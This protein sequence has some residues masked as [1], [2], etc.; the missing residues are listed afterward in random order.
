MDLDPF[1]SVAIGRTTVRVSRLGYGGASIGGLFQA[2]AEDDAVAAVG[3]SVGT[4]GFNASVNNGR[5]FISLKPLSVRGISSQTFINRVR[6][7]LTAVGGMR[8]FM[9]TAQDIRA[10]GR[11]TPSTYQ[12]TLWD[13]NLDELQAYVPRV[14]ARVQQVPEL[15]DV[16]N[17]REQG[18][19]QANVVIDRLAAALPPA[20]VS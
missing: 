8:V 20:V 13:P 15:A 11:Q 6:P 10:G 9:T 2:V 12:F 7:K 17:D 5:L 4:S 1:A 18:G 3:S 16:N 14:L 19:L